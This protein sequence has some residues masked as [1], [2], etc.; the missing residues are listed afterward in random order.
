M[1]LIIPCFYPKNEDRTRLVTV[2]NLRRTG[3][4]C[5]DGC[6]SQGVYQEVYIGWCTMGVYPE[7][8]IGGVYT[9]CIC[10]PTYLLPGYASLPTHHG[11]PYYTTLGTPCT[12]TM[13]T[14][15]TTVSM[16]GTPL[17]DDGALGSK[18]GIT[19]GRR[20]REPQSPKGVMVG[21]NLCA[22]TSAL[23]VDKCIKIG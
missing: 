18:A 4:L 1:R 8:Y 21:R 15:G 9:R 11:T 20:L 19:V 5:A 3:V 2:L 14:T 22:D 17:P 10:L 23:P 12:Y 7:V 16:L 13:P 6:L